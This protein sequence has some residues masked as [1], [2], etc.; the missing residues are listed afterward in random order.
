MEKTEID[1]FG[2]SGHAKVIIEALQSCS[3]N[4]HI[5]IYD[6]DIE[7][8]KCLNFEVNHDTDLFAKRKYSFI[9]G[10][11]EN[12]IR[13]EVYKRIKNS[14][15]FH[16]YVKHISANVSPSASVKEGTV[17][18]SNCVVNTEAK[19]GAH[20]ILNSGSIIE[21]NCV[22]ENF[23]HIS[24][25]ACLAGGVTVGEG[26]HVCSGA[27][28]IPGIKIGR[29]STIGAGAVIIRDVPDFAKVVGNPGR[30]L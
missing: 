19:I 22:V 27:T 8:K 23:A 17:I 6:D 9:I 20:C 30:V 24:P 4:F 3:N 21:H 16:D 29:W 14:V 28:V 5:N 18:F 10:I 11:G 15:V 12:L 1:I 25:N 7:K 2:A 13:K 26:A